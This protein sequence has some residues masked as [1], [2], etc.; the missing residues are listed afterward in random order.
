MALFRFRSVPTPAAVAATVL[1]VAAVLS[2]TPARAAP[3]EPAACLLPDPS[4][5]PAVSKPYFMLLVDTSGSMISPVVGAAPSCAGYSPTR[6]GHAKCAVKNTTLAFGGEVNFGLSQYAGFMTGCS[7][8]CYGNTSGFPFP[9]CNAQCFNAEINTTGVCGACG[10]MDNINDPTT[11]HGANILVGMQVDNVWNSPPGA[12]NPSNIPALLG[13]VDNVCT[14]NAELSNPPVDGFPGG[15]YGKTPINGALRDMKRYF[16]TGWTNP[17][18]AAISFPTPLNALDR[19]CRSVN[20][21][22][23]TDG[24]ETC[25]AQ[26]DAVN[27]AASLLAGVTVGGNLF[28]IKTYVI[29]FAGG[30]QGNTD[31]IASAGGTGLSYFATNEVQLSQALANIV[32]GAIKPE[33]CDNTDNNCNG[34]TDEGFTHYCNVQPVPANCCAWGT[35]AQRTTCLSNYTAS[36]TAANPQGTLTLLPC[37]TAAQVQP[38]TWLCKDPGEQCDSVD[39]NCVSGV[40]EGITKCGNPLHCPLAETCNGQD[41][42]CNGLIDEGGVCPN[43][44]APSVETC[45]GCDNDCNGVTDNGIAPIPCGIPQ[46]ATTPSW[47]AGTIT[48]K[49]PQ[50]VAVGLCAASGGGFNACNNAPQA[51]VCDGKDDNCNGII[52]DG[53]ASAP[54]VPT[55]QPMGLNYGPNSTC[56]MGT[57]ACTNG[58]TVCVGGVGPSAEICD[59][60][61]NN[62]D[63]IVDN[64]V[65]G[66]GLQCGVNQLPCTS[67]LSACVNGTLVCQGGNQP[68]PEVCNGIDDNCNGTVDEAPLTDAPAP[69][70]GGCWTLPGNCCTFKN[71]SWCPPPGGTCFDNGTLSPPCNKGSLACSGVTGWVCQ[72]PKNP[73][74]ETCDGID[75]DCNGA[76]D[77]GN[78][79]QVGQPCGSNTG[80]CK[81]GALSCTAGVLDCLGDVPP[82]AELCDGK[83]NDCDGTIDNGIVVGAACTVAY[84]TALY[85]GPRTA[86]PCQPGVLQCDGMGGQVCFGGVG[87]SPEV[88]DGIDNDCDGLIDEVGVAPDG[89]DGTANPLPPP[90]ANLGDACGSSTGECKAGAYHCVNGLF[91]CLGGQAATPETCDCD[92][93]DCDGVTDNPNGPNGPPLCGSGKDCVK[94]SAG[95][96]QCAQPCATGEFPCPPG[97]KCDTVTSSQTG[98]SLPVGYC[99]TDPDA[100][101]GNCALKTTKD[102]NG[103]V[104]CAPAGTVLD[105]CITPPVCTC[106]G[107]NGCVEPCSGVTCPAGLVCASFGPNTGACAA[108]SCYNNPCQGCG[109]ACNLGACVANPCTDVTCPAGQECKPTSNFTDHVCVPACG[110]VTC[111]MGKSCIDGVCADDCNPPCT[112]GQICDRTQAP[113]ACVASKCTPTTCTDG[114]CCDPITGAC[115][116][117]PCEGVLCPAGQVC[118]KIT[119]Q[120]GQSM[121][122]TGGSDP[123]STSAATGSSTTSTGASGTG[124]ADSSIWGLAT[125]GGGCSCEVG[126]GLAARLPDGRFAILALALIGLVARSR[127]GKRASANREVRS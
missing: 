57:S 96:C 25:D 19:A 61:D 99:V 38:A 107:Q 77:D 88:C 1:T 87:P 120:C 80:E 58:A 109:K 36:I 81:Q 6:M 33:T 49:P 42:N 15:Q 54:C 124:G 29:N 51:E 75:N 31:A 63:G 76:V 23:M 66:V 73:G 105:N 92:D 101:C 7:A 45:D 119:G 108:D 37:T 22:L 100:N 106:K 67:G 127:R 28:K 34:C 50:N 78:L 90:A 16:Q 20:V 82:S 26:T 14:G 35:T 10:P 27:A 9:A 56:K 118:S 102:A 94:G 4:A 64:N 2:P 83:D 115:G 32:S 95:S 43:A 65:P 17:D 69:G 5:W 11:R 21:I 62:C 126:V 39:N 48:C 72:N 52:D 53:I 121:Q 85:P 71:L 74:V 117:C 103:K 8:N 114:S 68:K 60:L 24:D 122:G 89:L 46:S 18:N 97:Q 93:N 86:L 116:N 55:G 79:P 91:A 44:C 47:C 113:P 112:A 110:N 104:L 98:Q 40:D 123:T 84:N 30:S 12:P 111:P 70:M 3:P 41:D 59:G 125:G 13:F